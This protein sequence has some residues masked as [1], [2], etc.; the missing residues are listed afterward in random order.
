MKV[1]RIDS[2]RY[3]IQVHTDGKRVLLANSQT[4]PIHV[5]QVGDAGRLPGDKGAAA[6][7]GDLLVEHLADHEE[8]LRELLNDAQYLLI[9]I[10]SSLDFLTK[11]DLYG[12]GKPE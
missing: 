1:Y 11:E 3:E 5:W 6:A 2:N 7:L 8:E 12:D 9:S 4:A 10:K